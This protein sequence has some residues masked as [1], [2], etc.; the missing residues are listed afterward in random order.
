MKD[1]VSALNVTKEVTYNFRTSQ[2]FPKRRS[3]MTLKK[4]N[5]VA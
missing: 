1:K 3:L 4:G 5:F 2:L